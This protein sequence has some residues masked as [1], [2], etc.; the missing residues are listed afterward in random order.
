[1]GGPEVSFETDQQQIVRWRICHTGEADLCF[2]ETCRRLLAGEP[3]AGKLIA[4][5]LPD[6]GQIELP[7]DYY[8][9][10]DVAHRIIYV[11]ASR[12]CPFTCEFCLSSLDVPGA[13]PPAAAL[14]GVSTIARS[15]GATFQVRGSDV[16][17]N[18]GVSKTLLE[19]FLE[20]LRPGLFLHSK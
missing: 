3:P 15:R 7:Y 20:R 19:F 8:D 17:L 11:E 16:N 12:G 10:K 2:V 4:A 6:P 9:E 13:V 14:G 18:L 1:V 5:T